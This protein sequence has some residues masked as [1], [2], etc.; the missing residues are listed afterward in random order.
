MKYQGTVKWFSNKKG[1]GFIAPTSDNAPTKDEIFVHQTA[2]VTD[3]AYRTLKENAT[4]SFEIEKEADTGK[5]KAVN[6]TNADGTPIVPPPRERRRR[7]T[8][9]KG[10]DGAADD[11]ADEPSPAA[12]GEAKEDEKPK[13]TGG[14]H[15]KPRGKNNKDESK[16]PAAPKE[17]PF[18]ASLEE[19]V[20]KKLEGK[21]LELGKRTTVDVAIGDSRIK[22]GQGG[23][24]GC[25]LASAVVGEGTYTCDTKGT[26]TFKWER[27]IEYKD[28][29]WKKGDASKLVASISLA[30]DAVGP[31][32]PEDTPETLWGKD[33]PEPKEA[34]ESMGFLM[35][36]VVLTRPR[37][38]GTNGTK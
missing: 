24:A 32:K 13:K 9:E 34:F 2:V 16:A 6:V 25:A 22:L 3:G 27:S 21:G 26:V 4:V 20:K 19:D 1:F 23:Y 7:Q 11:S 36:R 17:A 29:A 10:G 5:L 30:D 33:V 14:R 15:R 35:R 18:H 8:K 37:R 28:G 12:A 38:G 31:V